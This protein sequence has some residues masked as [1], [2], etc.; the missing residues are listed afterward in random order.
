MNC[1]ARNVGRSIVTCIDMF[2]LMDQNFIDIVQ[3]VMMVMFLISSGKF[4][5]TKD[6]M[7]F[8]TAFTR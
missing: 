7:L 1:I 3:S 2:I 6:T 8:K 5:K 4:C